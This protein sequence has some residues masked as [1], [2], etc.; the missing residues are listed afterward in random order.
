MKLRIFVSILYLLIGVFLCNCAGP[1]AI[2][3]CYTAGLVQTTEFKCTKAKQEQTGKNPGCLEK[4]D[5][6]TYYCNTA[7]TKVSTTSKADG[8]IY[9]AILKTGCYKV[10][11]LID[12][13]DNIFVGN[14]PLCVECGA[15]GCG[16][17][18]VE[19]TNEYNLTS[20]TGQFCTNFNP[21]YLDAINMDKNSTNIIK[22]PVLVK[23][24]INS[25][26]INNSRYIVAMYNNKKYTETLLGNAGNQY[27]IIEKDGT[28]NLSKDRLRKYIRNNNDLELT[29]EFDAYHV[30]ADKQLSFFISKIS[31]NQDVKTLLYKDFTTAQVPSSAITINTSQDGYTQRTFNID[32]YKNNDALGTGTEDIGT[33]IIAAVKGRQGNVTDMASALDYAF[34]KDA[35]TNVVAVYNDK[36]SELVSNNLVSSKGELILSLAYFKD[37]NDIKSSEILLALV[38]WGKKFNTV[39]QGLSIILVDGKYSSVVT[40]YD[41]R[42]SLI[43]ISGY[44]IKELDANK[45]AFEKSYIDPNIAGLTLRKDSPPQTSMPV[46]YIDLKVCNR[47]EPSI[48]AREYAI[49]AAIHE[50]GHAFST[51]LVTGNTNEEHTIYCNGKNKEYCILRYNSSNATQTSLD[52]HRNQL[53]QMG[54]CEG[55]I[56]MLLNRLCIQK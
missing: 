4:M 26:F 7:D 32:V 40:S 35:N 29:L 43:P 45:P 53:G 11:E 20:C 3:S 44:L 6:E 52:F 27:F 38:D 22:R 30:D 18:D 25:F 2:Y 31:D 12:W 17:K 28:I 9:D 51:Q 50:L 34:K 37:I 47:Y 41:N 36:I 39:K 55:H 5:R 33:Y 13:F 46:A 10:G 16:F 54:F 49:G 19:I 15:M 8:M 56:Q 23:V 21:I 42:A 1:P 24:V 14:P 48:P